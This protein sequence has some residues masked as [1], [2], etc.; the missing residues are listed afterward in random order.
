ML[1]WPAPAGS[2]VTLPGAD[3]LVHAG[4]FLLL[5][6]VSRLRFGPA[7]RVLAA[8]LAY[9]ALSEVVQAVLLSGRSGDLLDLLADA[10]GALV[11]WQ[12]ARRWELTPP[13]RRA[14]RQPGA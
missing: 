3:K 10:V 1:F 8:V 12:L 14:G 11:G 4:L 5:A 6:G 13:A 2:G 9:A 7:S